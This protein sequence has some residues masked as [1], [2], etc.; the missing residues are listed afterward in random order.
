MTQ[1]TRRS[2]WR[3]NIALF[4]LIVSCG[5]LIAPSLASVAIANGISCGQMRTGATCFVQPH[6]VAGGLVERPVAG[7][8][9][10]LTASSSSVSSHLVA[11]SAGKAATTCAAIARRQYVA[12][13]LS[14]G[15]ESFRSVV[16][17]G[18]DLPYNGSIRQLLRDW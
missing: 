9:G 2:Q 15:A 14:R 17:D 8:N 7:V 13:S 6:S 11:A 5:Q 4:I 12:P 1:M 16:L 10:S 18:S 3:L